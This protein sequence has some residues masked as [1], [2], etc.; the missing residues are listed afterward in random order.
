MN[1]WIIAGLVVVCSIFAILAVWGI[2]W[3]TMR[4]QYVSF[5][6]EVSQSIDEMIRWNEQKSEINGMMG[7]GAEDAPDN[8][9]AMTDEE[10]KYEDTLI[11]KIQDKLARLSEITVAAAKRNQAQKQ[12]VQGI[13][14]DISHQVKT[15]VANIRMYCD[16]LQNEQI[17]DELRTECLAVLE[18][19]TN[20][21][22]FLV[23]SMMKMS[24]L[25]N[26]MIHLHPETCNLCD[27]LDEVIRNV[28]GKAA[29]K[30]IEIALECPEEHFLQ[31]DEKWTAEALFNIVDNAVKYTGEG[32][33]IWITVTEQEIYTKIV[34]EDN[35]RGIAKEHLGDVCKRF[36]RE[37]ESS[38]EEGVGLGLYLAREILMMQ[39]GYLQIDSEAGAGTSVAV[40]LLN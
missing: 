22:D 34:V 20:K 33:S 24:R 39:K 19:Q 30:Y 4:E 37:E 1:H 36:F 18:Q 25:E 17:S 28:R 35:G 2:A 26:G 27:T 13:V 29:K 8:V 10:W 40:Y 31:Y 16:M 11:S 6:E 12:E 7:T 14:S 23:Q 15:P 21:L 5:T 3:A 38:G 9:R 32:G